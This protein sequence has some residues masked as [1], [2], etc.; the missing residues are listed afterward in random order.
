MTMKGAMRNCVVMRPLANPHSRPVVI[1]TATPTGMEN[2]FSMAMV[3]SSPPM[4]RIAPT[5]RSIPPMMMI[6]VM[7]SAM[8]LITAVCRTTLERFLLV[9]K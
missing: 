7:P 9:R 3:P 1:P 2:P 5:E 6:M 4:A 8:M